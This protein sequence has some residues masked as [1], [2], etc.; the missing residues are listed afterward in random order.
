MEMNLLSSTNNFITED[1][2]QRH[3]IK[4]YE[5]RNI[6]KELEA[7]IAPSMQENGI[8]IPQEESKK[9]IEGI[10]VLKDQLAEILDKNHKIS[11]SIEILQ[12]QMQKSN[13]DPNLLE[14]IKTS[15]FQ[16]GF[17][18][19]KTKAQ[20]ELTQDLESQKEK[21]IY[22]IKSLEEEAQKMQ[23]QIQKIKN[24]LN[25]IAL[26][27]AREVILKEVEENSAKIALLIANELLGQ[28]EKDTQITI[29]VHPVDFSYLQEKLSDHQ[30]IILQPD[31]S[32]GKGGVVILSTQ[33]NFD[34]SILARYKNLKR[35]LLDEKGL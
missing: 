22:A 32:V 16:Q 33:G 12:Q 25:V 21:M 30:K 18:E 26:D 8:Y 14:E 3:I 4:K 13:E 29:K 20:E 34:G 1:E 11:Q 31:I 7:Q 24:D 28:M 19:G 15:S 2:V 17:L 6:D 9:S 10:E 23:T 5:F 27:L 35:S